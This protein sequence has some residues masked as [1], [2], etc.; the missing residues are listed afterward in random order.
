MN[1]NHLTAV[2]VIQDPH[3]RKVG[4]LFQEMGFDYVGSNYKIFDDASK[5]PLGEVDLIFSFEK[6]LF[7]IEVTTKNDDRSRKKLSFFSKWSNE[8]YLKKLRDQF[9]LH[10]LT[11]VRIYFDLSNQ[12]RHS[13]SKSVEPMLTTESMNR[14][15]DKSDFNHF[16]E[17]TKKIG[18]WAKNDFLYWLEISPKQEFVPVPAIQYYIDDIPIFCFVSSVDILLKSCYVSR[19]RR[20]EVDEGYQRAFNVNRMKEIQKNIEN[21]KGLTF[22][23]SILIRLPDDDYKPYPMDQCPKSFIF[24]FPSGYRSCRIIDGQHRLLGFSNIPKNI[25]ERYYLPV[26]ALSN[27]DQKK[28]IKTFIDINS[29]QQRINQNLILS[30]RSSF[31]WKKEDKEFK[32]SIGVKTAERLRNS[33]FKNRIYFGGSD[34]YQ[35]GKI[36]LVTLVNAMLK[37]NQIKET[38]DETYDK[39]YSLLRIMSKAML[40]HL[41]PTGYFGQNKGIRVL[42]RL[43]NLFE[44]NISKSKISV[45]V[46][47]FFTDLKPVI[48]QA[49]KDNRFDD[50]FGEGGALGASRALLLLLIEKYPSK[51][52]GMAIDL[53]N[54]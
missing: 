42:F 52:H 30:L 37:N 18:T 33:F 32:E 2:N 5:Q 9:D 28:E 17:S 7:L 47:E 27:Y 41:L 21:K 15:A 23:N 1:E 35:S 46:N 20:G 26:I 31:S 6:F 8:E 24:K 19:R 50:Y 16:V 48:D 39:V 49:V 34:E 25:Q 13:A 54:L 4:K 38:V 43:V 29:T 45:T 40:E 22:P 51:Y 11:V 44:R 14:V 12:T 3:E 53:K 10:H 36:T